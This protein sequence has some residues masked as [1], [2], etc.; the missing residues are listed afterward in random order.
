MDFYII[1]GVER[2]ASRTDVE[3]AYTRLARR[4]HPDINPG[5]HEAAAFFRRAT[6][7]YE[8][9]CDPARRRAY[10]SDGE[11][12]VVVQQTSVEFSGFDF[13]T[14]VPGAS[15]TF[16]D[17]FA[18]V[19]TSPIE[20]KVSDDGKGSDLHG[21]IALSFEEALHGTER[22]LTVTRLAACVVCGGS[23]NRRAAESRC[24]QC[25]GSGAT[26]W[27]RGHMV[28][29]K[30]C[31]RCG[32]SGLQRQQPCTACRA[33]GTATLNDQIT[34]QVP[35]GVMDG[36]RMRV[37]G[38]G[39]AGRRGSP[40]G[41]L[42]VTARVGSHRLFCRDGDDL[43]LQVPIGVH[44]AALGATITIPTVTGSTIMEIPAG[45]QSGQAFRL[46]DLGATSPRTGVCGDLVVEVQIVLPRLKDYR[47]KEL[48]REFG[49]INSTDIRRKLFVK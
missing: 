45:T 49:Q 7:A 20:R 8:T 41:D 24:G 11:P 26:Q 13:S 23:G 31:D 46:P 27:R 44:E 4:Y 3:R 32:G 21:E 5:D 16:G 43:T 40:V 19:L 36:A 38:K 42:Y 14:P 30:S 48:L 1:L 17:L 25:H 9:L 2:S 33:E 34:I 29:S 15:A 39:N 22:Q 37:P 18:E 10:D 28:F 35:A 6:E 47:S 12:S